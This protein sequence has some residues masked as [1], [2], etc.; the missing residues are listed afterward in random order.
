M[1]R[2]KSQRGVTLIELMIAMVILTIAVSGAFLMG[3][4]LKKSYIGQRRAMHI[5]RIA[6]SLVDYIGSA[7]RA[8]S[9]GVR[10]GVIFDCVNAS[11]FR[12][13]EVI[14]SS[15]G[16]DELRLVWAAGIITTSREVYNSG[17]TGVEIA[18]GTQ[19]RVGDFIVISDLNQ[20]YLLK[21]TGKE[22]APQN[23]TRLLATQ[24]CP[25]GGVPTLDRGALIMRV[26]IGRFW[27]DG[28][29]TLWMDGDG[30]PQGNP[31]D[32]VTDMTNAEPIGL[33]VEDLQIAVGADTFP[34]GPPM[35]DGVLDEN[36]AGANDDEWY[37][38]NAGDQQP[39][40]AP[41]MSWQNLR[42]TLT[43]RSATEGEIA[44]RAGNKRPAAENHGAATVD[45]AFRR[46]TLSTQ[47]QIRNLRNDQ[48]N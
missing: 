9:P 45:D 31:Y 28:A 4:S 10:S 14:D 8:A 19:F 26:Q 46:R 21:V 16:P 7:V 13:L 18:D 17:S 25:A 27:V 33:G 5:E 38:N 22:N 23:T 35:G 44:G 40:N 20:G 30:W 39:S 1:I 15:A 6:R 29:Q 37:G 43:V 34:A 36:G 32:P 47:V 3:S 41:V 11:G 24:N 48:P 2:G 12:G 42:I